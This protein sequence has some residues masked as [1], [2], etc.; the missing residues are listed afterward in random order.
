MKK[1]LYWNDWYV[2]IIRKGFKVVIIIIFY[3]IK[4][5]IEIKEKE[6]LYII[7]KWKLIINV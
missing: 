2:L 6:K 5:N 4:E 1:C 3:E 7:V